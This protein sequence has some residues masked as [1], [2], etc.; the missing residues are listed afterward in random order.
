MIS[1]IASDLYRSGVFKLGEFKLKSGDISPF[2]LDLRLIPSIPSLFKK[3]IN[4]YSNLV[5]ELDAVA[6]AG[7]MSAGV[8][9]ATGVC[10]ELDLP[11]LQIRSSKK[12]HGTKKMVEGIVPRSGS[13]VILIDDLI[14]T[15]ASKLQPKEELEK[16]DLVV[17]DLVVLVDRTPGGDVHDMLRDRGL[18]LHS[19]GTIDN[20]FS[21]LKSSNDIPE[22]ELKRIHKAFEMWKS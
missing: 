6:L 15:G 11:L 9:F 5:R 17:K 2:Y 8:P 12:E 1:E 14:S 21:A 10:L 16:L 7:I 18:K 13:E 3:V 19:A 4:I 22:S 20:I